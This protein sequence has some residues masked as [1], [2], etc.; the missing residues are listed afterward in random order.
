MEI[1]SKTQISRRDGQYLRIRYLEGEKEKEIEVEK[2]N[3]DYNIPECIPKHIAA[4]IGKI[5][6]KIDTA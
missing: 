3:Q 2:Q 1:L 4:Y 5:N 6:K